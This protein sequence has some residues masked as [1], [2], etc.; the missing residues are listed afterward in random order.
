MRGHTKG[1]PLVFAPCSIVPSLS[2]CWQT[3]SPA[4]L[5]SLESP[6]LATG[7]GPDALVYV[8]HVLGVGMAAGL[9]N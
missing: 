8:W 2:N 9:T 5:S 7:H 4:G 3:A 6:P 1:A